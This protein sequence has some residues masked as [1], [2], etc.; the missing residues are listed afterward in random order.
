MKMNKRN[1]STLIRRMMK[2]LFLSLTAILM[3]FLLCRSKKGTEE[4][5]LL[6]FLPIEQYDSLQN[7]NI[8][9]ECKTRWLISNLNA[10]PSMY[11]YESKW[12]FKMTK[13]VYKDVNPTVRC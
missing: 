9:K 3:N 5:I 1:H 7:A 13:T 8:N 10:Y 4:L 11:L 2:T 6:I 12:P